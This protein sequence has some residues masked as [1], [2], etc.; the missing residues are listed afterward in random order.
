MSLTARQ[1]ISYQHLFHIIHVTRSVNT[2]TGVPGVETYTLG[3]TFVPALSKPTDN[4][5]TVVEG[6]GRVKTPNVFTMD[7]VWM[8][9]STN[10]R[11]ADIIKDVSLL[12]DGSQSPNYGSY[13]R[14]LGA[15]KRTPASGNR[16]ANEL[17]IRVMTMEKVPAGLPI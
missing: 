10:I 16:N 17:M 3:P 13:S 5:D 12:P 15:P 9:S 8:E 4:I 6:A 7:F 11:D 14:V 2:S 1:Q